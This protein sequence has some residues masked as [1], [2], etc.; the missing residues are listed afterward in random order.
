MSEIEEEGPAKKPGP[1]QKAAT[2]DEDQADTDHGYF[3]AASPQTV[4]A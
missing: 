2:L 3:A 4:G 1:E